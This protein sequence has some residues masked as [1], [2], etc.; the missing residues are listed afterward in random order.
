M[1]LQNFTTPHV[2]LA[3]LGTPSDHGNHYMTFGPDNMLY[4]NLGAPF[5]IGIPPAVGEHGLSYATIAKMSPNGTNVSTYATGEYCRLQICIATR[6]LCVLINIT[7]T[8][9]NECSSFK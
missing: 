8:I 5:N 2:V 6:P 7:T 4:F 3:G 9:S 1:L